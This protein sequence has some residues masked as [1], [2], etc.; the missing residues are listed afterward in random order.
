M[1]VLITFEKKKIHSKFE[2]V[3]DNSK[4]LTTDFRHTH[5]TNTHTLTHNMRYARKREET[6]EQV[7]ECRPQLKP[8]HTQ[9][10]CQFR[11]MKWNQRQRLKLNDEID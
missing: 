6:K 9:L 2:F 3:T 7:H 11:K 5:I 8:T 1:I 10:H 4:I